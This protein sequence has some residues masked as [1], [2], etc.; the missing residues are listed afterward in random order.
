LSEQISQV[1][2]GS[3]GI[4]QR[5]SRSGSDLLLNGGSGTGA[6]LAVP[7]AEDL[8]V[9]LV[10]TGSNAANIV[11]LPEMGIYSADQKLEGRQGIANRIDLGQGQA[12]HDIGQQGV[13]IANAIT[14]TAVRSVSQL[15]GD[16]AVQKVGNVADSS[17]DVGDL[18]QAGVN[19]ANLAFASESIGTGAQ[20]FPTGAVQQVD[21]LVTLRAGATAASIAQSGVNIGNLLSADRIDQVTRV[22]AGT[23]QVT[24]TVDFGSGP[25]PR[26]ITQS[27]VNVANLVVASEIGTL[28]QV[29]TGRQVTTN[30]VVDGTLKEYTDNP[31]GGVLTQQSNQNY[32]NIV[33]LKGTKSDGQDIVLS[34]TANFPQSNAGSPASQV[35]NSMTIN[36]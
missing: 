4:D 26:Q 21:N 33:I 14:A 12:L 19:A 35:G 29:S 13:N 16:A 27:G 1:F 8:P 28:N 32:V 20:D 36:N 18:S 10:Q 3:Q 24:N 6:S 31:F 15:L 11:G 23:Q 5:L 22:F 17:S 9:A 2:S 7:A 25:M 34:Q 30:T